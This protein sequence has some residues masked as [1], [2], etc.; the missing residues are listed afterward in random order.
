MKVRFSCLPEW[1]PYLPKPTLAAGQLPDWLKAMPSQA[2]SD[3]LAGAEVR[4]VKQCPPFI[5]AMQS[6]I[7][8]PL[9]ADLPVKDGE[10]SWNWDLPAHAESSMTRSPIGVHVPEQAAG[11]RQQACQV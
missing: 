3:T 11:S 4:T 2:K 9:A 10:F 7:L 1:E 8:F 6:G 5:D